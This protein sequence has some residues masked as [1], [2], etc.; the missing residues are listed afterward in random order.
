MVSGGKCHCVADGVCPFYFFNWCFNLLWG[1]CLFKIIFSVIL[2]YWFVITNQVIQ[3][4][5][6]NW[7]CSCYY[8]VQLL[9]WW[10]FPSQTA[11]NFLTIAIVFFSLTY[12]TLHWFAPQLHFTNFCIKMVICTSYFFNQHFYIDSERCVLNGKLQRIAAWTLHLWLWW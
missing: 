9:L 5:M 2:V 10:A 3:L 12:E 1:V 4:E 7:K 11:H 8:K 6:V